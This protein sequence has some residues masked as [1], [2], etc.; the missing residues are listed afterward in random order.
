[1]SG[2][3]LLIEIYLDK[4]ISGFDLDLRH[5]LVDTIGSRQLGE[6]ID[7]TSSPEMMEVVLNVMRNE[8]IED[9]LKVLLN[10]LGFNNYTIKD[11][12]DND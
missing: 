9:N 10:S 6:I 1:M 7:E 2:R 5:L 8:H 4:D 11:I 12:T 3:T